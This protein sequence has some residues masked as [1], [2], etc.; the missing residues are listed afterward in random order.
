LA[1]QL[2]SGLSVTPGHEFVKFVDLVDLVISDAT[3][4][5]RKPCLGINAVELGR[6]D[7]GVGD[8]S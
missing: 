5:V 6:F 2:R 7:Q 4:D 1:S 8:G 3:K